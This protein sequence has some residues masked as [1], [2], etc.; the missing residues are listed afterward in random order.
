MPPLTRSSDELEYLRQRVDRQ[1]HSLAVLAQAVCALRNANAAL[2]DENRDLQIEL[3]RARRARQI[4][5]E[6][7]RTAA[8]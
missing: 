8:A 3:Q 5:R 7:G 1:D 6:A 2:R 4:R